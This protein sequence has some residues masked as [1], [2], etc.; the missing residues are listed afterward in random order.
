M[1]TLERIAALARAIAELK[2]INDAK[3]AEVAKQRR[4]CLEGA[5]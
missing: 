1:T 4:E 5:G 3:R 2:A